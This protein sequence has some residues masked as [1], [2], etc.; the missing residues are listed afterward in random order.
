MLPARCG[1]SVHVC[2]SAWD[3]STPAHPVKPAGGGHLAPAGNGST[4]AQPADRY[5]HAASPY[6]SV[7]EPRSRGDESADILGDLGDNGVPEG[8]TSVHPAGNP[9]SHSS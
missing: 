2:T 9:I 7:I 6:G 5:A 8:S 3:G 4:P 1:P